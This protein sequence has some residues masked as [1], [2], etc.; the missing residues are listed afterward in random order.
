MDYNCLRAG[1]LVRCCIKLLRNKTLLGHDF[2]DTSI[3]VN[4]LKRQKYIYV[5]MIVF[6]PIS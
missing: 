6:D 2:T 4:K 5:E 1:G 3:N